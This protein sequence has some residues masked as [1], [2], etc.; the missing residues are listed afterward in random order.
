MKKPFLNLVL[1][2]LTMSA[3][4]QEKKDSIYQVKIASP[5]V[6]FVPV[7]GG[8]YKVFTQKIGSGR[9][10]L[11]LLSGGPGESHEYFENF[12]EHLAGADV[13]IYMYEQLGN[14]FSDQPDDSS[15]WHVDRFAAEVEEVRQGLGIDQFFLLGHSWGG[16]LGEVY[17]AKYGQHLKGLILSNIPGFPANDTDYFDAVLDSM[18]NVVRLKT[19]QLPR[20]A[21][22]R[23]QIDSISRGQSLSDS[24]LFSKLRKEY[25]KVNDSLFGRTMYYRKP[26]KIPDPLARSTK[27][28]SLPGGG[29]YTFNIFEVD[30]AAM[31]RKIDKPV[32]L[33]GSR[34]DFL[35]NERY[36]ELKKQMTNTKVRVYL[37]PEGA[38]FPMWDD[39]GNY[40]RELGRF[41]KEVS[42]GKFKG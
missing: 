1:I 39:T 30:Y 6:R 14:Y 40:F 34:Y 37:C 20:F 41:I 28:Y 8:K 16:M 7:N 27:H 25:R 12:A 19:V 42:Q 9:N 13:T 2:L 18:E 4:S 17:A 21:A 5:G 15:I 38:H 33:L 3:F 32:L 31:L 10:S 22:H 36:D 23:E 35:H 29:K 26:G 24:A 11:L